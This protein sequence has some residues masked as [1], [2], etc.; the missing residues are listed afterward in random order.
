[1]GYRDARRRERQRVS[2]QVRMR[3]QPA[4]FYLRR[5]RRDTLLHLAKKEGLAPGGIPACVLP[6]RPTELVGIMRRYFRQTHVKKNTVGASA[7]RRLIPAP[8][9]CC[10]LTPSLAGL[11][12]RLPPPAQ[13]KAVNTPSGRRL[14]HLMRAWKVSIESV[15]PLLG[16]GVPA[17]LGALAAPRPSAPAGGAD[18]GRQVAL[19][20]A[21]LGLVAA[22]P[23][24]VAT[25]VFAASQLS[26]AF[27]R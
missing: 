15:Q 3:V 2:R 6:D 5:V 23:V 27:Q 26:A 9:A 11:H 24:A 1:M 13:L 10:A 22:I 18:E 12:P 16:N 7:R 8:P 4:N 19:R 17:D 25:G 21:M 20:N 14:R